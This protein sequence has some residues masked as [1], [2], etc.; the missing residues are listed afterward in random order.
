MDELRKAFVKARFAQEDVFGKA[1]IEEWLESQHETKMPEET[2]WRRFLS[3][4]SIEI[5]VEKMSQG[6]IL[7][8]FATR[9]ADQDRDSIMKAVQESGHYDWLCNLLLNLPFY[10]GRKG[11]YVLTRYL[12]FFVITIEGDIAQ[13]RHADLRRHLVC[14]PAII[15]VI[16]AEWQNKRPRWMIARHLLCS[17]LAADIA[18]ERT[19]AEN[20]FNRAVAVS[21]DGT[22]IVCAD[23][24]IVITDDDK[25]L[26]YQP[27]AFVNNKILRDDKILRHGIGGSRDETPNPLNIL[28]LRERQIYSSGFLRGLGYDWKKRLITHAKFCPNPL[29]EGGVE[30]DV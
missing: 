25:I 18:K 6:W 23:E 17:V 14:V 1:D 16:F 8:E 24:V 21:E 9:V 29:P 15:N 12:E 30:L 20:D 19:K 11:E 3:R 10:S 13:M 5:S 28:I 22:K 2:L 7:D 4:N 26:V 27:Q